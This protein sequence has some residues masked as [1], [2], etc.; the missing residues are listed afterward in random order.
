MKSTK[1]LITTRLTAIEKAKH[2]CEEK[3]QE[4]YKDTID[5]CEGYINTILEEEAKKASMKNSIEVE[6]LFATVQDEFENNYICFLKPY[7][8]RPFGH[9]MYGS[10]LDKDV[11]DAYL[12]KYHF[13]TKWKKG[14]YITYQGLRE[15]AIYLTISVKIP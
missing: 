2:L 11:M 13:K 10:S 6:I 4:H 9:F 5:F 3:K 7:E 1:E 15:E 12:R 14:L 8:N